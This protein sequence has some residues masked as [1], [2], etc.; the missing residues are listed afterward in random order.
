M[1]I[2]AMRIA[3][4][5]NGDYWHT[6]KMHRSTEREPTVA[7][8][9]RQKFLA[10]KEADI[11]LAFV[12]EWD[13]INNQDEVKRALALLFADRKLTPILQQLTTPHPYLQDQD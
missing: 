10:A 9:H 1:F 3:V 5:F 4:E 6:D 2:P 11:T 8:K 13:W 12:W 7:D